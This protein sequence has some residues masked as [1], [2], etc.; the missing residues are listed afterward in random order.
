MTPV[1]GAICDD[2]TGAT[3]LA[4]LVRR[5]GA[6]VVLRVGLPEAGA[7][8]EGAVEVV[9]LKIRTVPAAEAVDAA[10]AAARWLRKGGCARLYWKYCSTFDST[11]L[12]NIGPVAEALRL[13]VRARQ[14]VYCPAF[15]ENGRRVFRG[16]LF[17][18]DALLSDSPMRDHPLTPMR[19]ASLLRLLAPQV[20][21]EVGLAP[22]E[23]VVEG[24]DALGHHLARLDR[25]GV[26]HVIL[27]AIE[28]G[29]LDVIAE[30]LAEWPLLTGGS[31]LAGALARLLVARGM[32]TLGTDNARPMLP[33]S[34]TLAL[35]GSLSEAS[36]AQV[37]AFV[38]ARAIPIELDPAGCLADPVTAAGEAIA[39]VA[40]L[41][42]AAPCV[43][44]AQIG[45]GEVAALQARAGAGPVG[46]AV[47]T[48][49]ARVAVAAARSGRARLAVAGG[50][51]SGAVAA[52][53]GL[54]ALRVGQEIAP[55]VPWCFGTLPDALGGGPVAVVFKSGNFGGADFFTEAFAALGP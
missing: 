17:V 27:D 24:A 11:P 19:D 38:A 45:P 23:T 16:H 25:K 33:G 7:A 49:L 39:A 21:T 3:D 41:P 43:V 32:M 40:R 31:A 34:G 8:A 42:P 14:S 54:H 1:L 10:T 52:A 47:E 4:A 35:A 12:G 53:L 28:D 29:D 15:P 36:R 26:R 6:P 9:A 46:A 22:R 20:D 2:L 18:Q 50:E 51:T 48:V 44:H 13:M 55:G 30:A 5:S 37:A